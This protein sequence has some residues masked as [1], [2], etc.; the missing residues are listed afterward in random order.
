M[1]NSVVMFCK[2]NYCKPMCQIQLKV[3]SLESARV[4]EI[5]VFFNFQLPFSSGENVLSK[6]FV[7]AI[8]FSHKRADLVSLNTLTEPF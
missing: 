2:Q 3:S 7:A 4:K 1:K 5:S 8:C 6:S